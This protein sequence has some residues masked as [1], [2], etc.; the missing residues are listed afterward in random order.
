MERENLQKAIDLEENIKDIE[1]RM[2][3]IDGKN[4]RLRIFAA[5]NDWVEWDN[6]WEEEKEG[7]PER[8][9]A[10]LFIHNMRDKMRLKKEALLREMAKL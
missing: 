1:R 7:D 3:L 10:V 6:L 4:N 8:I 9:L 2:E 5:N